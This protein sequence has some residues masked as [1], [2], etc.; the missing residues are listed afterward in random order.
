MEHSPIDPKDVPPS[1]VIIPRKEAVRGQLE[2]AIFL[3]FHDADPVSIHT[4]VTAAR[5]VIDSIDQENGHKS[6]VTAWLEAQPKSVRER[7][8]AP[9]NFFKH[10]RLGTRKK[11]PAGSQEVVVYPPEFSEMLLMDALASYQRLF[12][13]LKPIMTLFT[14]RFRVMHPEALAKAANDIPLKDWENK[15]LS[16]LSKAEFLNQVLPLLS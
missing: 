10:G 5:G 8:Y 1:T 15:N 4:L 9:Q 6:P 11:I 7:I 13:D 14:L 2:A 3:W 12:N 16:N